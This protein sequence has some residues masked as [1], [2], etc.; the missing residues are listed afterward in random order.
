MREVPKNHLEN[1]K[2]DKLRKVSFGIRSTPRSSGLNEQLHPKNLVVA[3][4]QN[5]LKSDVAQKVVQV[6]L[7]LAAS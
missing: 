6:K 3:L 7:I 4:T 2:V 5:L 1:F